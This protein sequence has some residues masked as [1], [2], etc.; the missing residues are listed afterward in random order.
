MVASLACCIAL[1][2]L[3][4][5]DNYL[6]HYTISL[7]E[8]RYLAFYKLWVVP[9]PMLFYT[10]QNAFFNNNKKVHFGNNQ[11]S[12]RSEQ[13]VAEGY[14][15]PFHKDVYTRLRPAKV[16]YCPVPVLT[17]WMHWSSGSVFSRNLRMSCTTYPVYKV[18]P[19][20]FFKNLNYISL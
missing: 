2:S 16:V 3:V 19:L 1:F 5:S 20:V 7:S 4:L 18:C 10:W 8:G 9:V 12:K 6:F 11:V 15:L 13:L 14:F 17:K